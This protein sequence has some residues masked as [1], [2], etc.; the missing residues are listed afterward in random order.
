MIAPHPYAQMVLAVL[1]AV[2]AFDANPSA[3]KFDC[4]IIE[5]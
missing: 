3:L 1:F 2:T 4:D 5:L